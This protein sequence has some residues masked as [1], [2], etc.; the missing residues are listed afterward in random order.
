MPNTRTPS[1][2][3]ERNMSGLR[4]LK[5]SSVSGGTD[6]V[7]DGGREK[8]RVMEERRDCGHEFTCPKSL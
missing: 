5:E 6:E 4:Y 1:C 3:D 8:H 7:R 2:E